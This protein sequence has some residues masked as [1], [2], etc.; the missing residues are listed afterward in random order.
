M[1]DPKMY[2]IF[3]Q[4]LACAIDKCPERKDEIISDAMRCSGCPY[5]ERMIERELDHNCEKWMS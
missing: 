1:I 5:L 4:Q 3:L 2:D